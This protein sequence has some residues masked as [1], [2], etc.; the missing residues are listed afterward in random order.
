MASV[1][2]LKSKNR[3]TRDQVADLLE[4]LAANIRTG[5]LS[6]SHGGEPVHLAIPEGVQLD[7]EISEDTRPEGVKRELE[8]EMHWRETVDGEPV[9][10]LGEL[11]IH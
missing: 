10:P 7:V 1:R 6:M 5:E 8:L 2:L 9:S 3:L 4:S 11:Q